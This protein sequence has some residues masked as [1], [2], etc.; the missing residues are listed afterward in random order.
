MYKDNAICEK[1]IIKNVIFDS[2]VP[3]VVANDDAAGHSNLVFDNIKEHVVCNH[4][5][6]SSIPQERRP[7]NSELRA[8]LN[9]WSEII[10]R[11]GGPTYKKFPNKKTDLVQYVLQHK[12][13]TI[14]VPYFRAPPLPPSDI[15]V[16][17]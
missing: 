7:T 9:V 6:A 11:N 10:I 1:K 5:F 12:G 4:A 14:K 2:N 13:L 17:P 8:F 15:N 3:C 16:A